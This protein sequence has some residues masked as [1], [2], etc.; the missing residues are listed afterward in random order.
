M[1]GRQRSRRGAT[2][3]TTTTHQQECRRGDDIGKGFSNGD[4]GGKG[5]GK[6]LVGRR[7][8]RPAT[9]VGEVVAGAFNGGGRVAAFND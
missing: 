3:N 7:Q 8:R 6:G 2:D 5:K 9:A 4:S 1:D